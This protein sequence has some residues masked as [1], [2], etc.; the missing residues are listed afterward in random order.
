MAVTSTLKVTEETITAP[1]AVDPVVN[2]P[3]DPRLAALAALQTVPQVANT[4]PGILAPPVVVEIVRTGDTFVINPGGSPFLVRARKY[5]QVDSTGH[6]VEGRRGDVLVLDPAG[7][8]T[9]WAV[10]EGLLI[11]DRP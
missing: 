7:E 6:R 11:P 10:T 1:P 5:P 3:V 8:R 9:Q 4:A 2:G